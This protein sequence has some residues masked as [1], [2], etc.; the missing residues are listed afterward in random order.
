MESLQTAFLLAILVL[1][2]GAIIRVTFGFGDA[3]LGMPL[4]SLLLGVKIATPVIAAYG[5]LLAS[6]ILI[7][8]WRA[9]RF[10]S[11]WRLILASLVGIPF[12][13]F[14]IHAVPEQVTKIGLGVILIFTSLFNVFYPKQMPTT[15]VSSAY[16][17][18]LIAGILGSAY[19]TNGPPILI[20]G[21]MRK[22]DPD[23]FRA[24]MQ[25]YFLPT[26]L[27]IIISHVSSG[28]WTPQVVRLFLFALPVVILAYLLGSQIAKH[29]TPEKFKNALYALV[30]CMGMIMIGTSI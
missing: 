2:F 24:T 20:Y 18:G 4:I 25:S 9:I 7:R 17:F 8:E 5:L 27:F 16:G 29:I 21:L 14:Y 10:N 3:L 1:G 23:S 13:I 11:T 6:G 22:W 12:G 19:N 15:P 30:F 26:N 28:L